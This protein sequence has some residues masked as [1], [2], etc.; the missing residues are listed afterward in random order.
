M[1][2]G[3]ATGN[4]M[5]GS[6]DIHFGTSRITT[7]PILTLLRRISGIGITQPRCRVLS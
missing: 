7:S 2:I 6:D 5:G 1:V 3:G 4:A